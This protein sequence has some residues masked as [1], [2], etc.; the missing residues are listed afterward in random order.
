MSVKKHITKEQIDEIWKE[1]KKV[2]GTTDYTRY[3]CECDCKNSKG[4]WK[5]IGHCVPDSPGMIKV[6]KGVTWLYMYDGKYRFGLS[7]Y[8]K[9]LL[10]L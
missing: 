8:C 4:V 2:L 3:L 5:F 10:G 9:E 1:H 7:S 6:I